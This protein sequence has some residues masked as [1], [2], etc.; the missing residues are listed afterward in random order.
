MSVE[1]ARLRA[2]AD[3]DD[4]G[5]ARWALFWRDCR[6]CCQLGDGSAD[7][8]DEAGDDGNGADSFTCSARYRRTGQQP[9][10]ACGAA[11]VKVVRVL[12]APTG[13]A[14]TLSP[15]GVGRPGI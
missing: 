11:Q 8:D 13:V 9:V 6:N 10:R 14:P 2:E 15:D 5:G 3:D 12:V 7:D 4:E 1:T